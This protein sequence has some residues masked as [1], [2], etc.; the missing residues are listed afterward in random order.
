MNKEYRE[1]NCLARSLARIG[2]TAD[3]W[4]LGHSSFCKP[5]DMLYD[6]CD[7]ILFLENY[8]TSG[9]TPNLSTA[10]K[11]K[12][13][14][15]IDGHVTIRHHIDLAQINKFDVILNSCLNS[16]EE[17]APFCQESIWFPNAYPL[18]LFSDVSGPDTREIEFGYVGSYGSLERR[19][20]ITALAKE[21]RLQVQTNVVGDSMVYALK[22]M[23]LG[24]NKNASHDINYRTFETTGAG[25][26][27]L[28]DATP[29]I[30]Q[31]FKIG[32]EILTYQDYST[33]CSVIEEIRRGEI[34]II[35]VA[36]LG[37]ARVKKDH[38]YDSRAKTFVSQVKEML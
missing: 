6:M 3:V 37:H 26:A 36:Q 24:F 35:Q 8:D 30:D 32:S 23:Q 28:T 18:D 38:T 27:L 5:F 4:G 12:L 17:L 22:S 21:Q 11:P 34:D 20:Y 13:F 14:W 25:A 29:G 33:C 10:K 16:V 31:L 9:W 15:S 1:C 7:A 2:V 19:A